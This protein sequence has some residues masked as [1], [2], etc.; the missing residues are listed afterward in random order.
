MTDMKINVSQGGY[1]VW[2]EIIIGEMRVTIKHTEFLRLENAMTEA[3]REILCS[4][5]QRDWHTFDPKL[6]SS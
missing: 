3:R 1:P 5:D 4:L 6:A 2:V